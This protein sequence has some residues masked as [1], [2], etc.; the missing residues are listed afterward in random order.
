MGGGIKKKKEVGG[1]KVES[2][3]ERKDR[4][5]GGGIKTGGR[6]GGG[7]ISKKIGGWEGGT[8]V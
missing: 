4:R 2:K 3:S 8:N 5:V 7:A 1:W 6:V